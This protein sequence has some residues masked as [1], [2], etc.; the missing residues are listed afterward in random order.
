M[1]I[2]TSNIKIISRE[3]QQTNTNTYKYTSNPYI[4]NKKIDIMLNRSIA[5]YKTGEFLAEYFETANEWFAHRSTYY[6][7]IIIM[8]NIEKLVNQFIFYSHYDFTSSLINK[9]N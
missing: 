6:E 1:N 9:K 8:Q 5:I 2:Q 3:S 4:K 7:L